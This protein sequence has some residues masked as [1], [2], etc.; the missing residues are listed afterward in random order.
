[1]N[2]KMLAECIRHDQKIIIMKS[3]KNRK[4]IINAIY[5]IA[6]V[7]LIYGIYLQG[8]NMENKTL[9]ISGYVAMIIAVLMDIW[10]RRE[11]KKIEAGEKT[12]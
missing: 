9:R 11:E 7:L 10:H 12:D 8:K 5:V 3:R 6:C 1:M 2:K 4:L